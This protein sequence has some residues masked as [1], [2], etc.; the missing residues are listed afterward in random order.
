MKALMFRQGHRTAIHFGVS[1]TK[2]RLT[3]WYYWMTTDIER[4]AKQC[5]QWLTVKPG[6][7]IAK[8][9]LMQEIAGY[10]WQRIVSDV[11]LG[12]KTMTCSNV[13]M[14]VVQDYHTSMCRCIPYRITQ[15]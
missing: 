3:L 2:K 11:I 1:R 8:L 5:H 7:G 14:L 9:P 10:R 12:F 13:V 4:W 15:H 6:I